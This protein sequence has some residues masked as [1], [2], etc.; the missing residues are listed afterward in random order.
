VFSVVFAPDGRTLA[1]GSWDTTVILWDL[2]AF[3]ALR[4]NPLPA[5]CAR[6]GNAITQ[7]TWDLYAPGIPYRHPCGA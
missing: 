3:N 4:A 5:A 2:T 1:T 7:Q 6:G